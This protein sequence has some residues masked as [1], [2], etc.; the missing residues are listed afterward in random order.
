MSTAYISE[1]SWFVDLN[2][3]S[4]C[5]SSCARIHDKIGGAPM[6]PS[7]ASGFPTCHRATLFSRNCRPLF[8][9]FLF[10]TS[11]SF[12]TQQQRCTCLMR[13]RFRLSSIQL[14]LF[15]CFLFSSS[16]SSSSFFSLHLAGCC[17]IRETRH[18]SNISPEIAKGRVDHWFR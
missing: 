1:P 7:Y 12:L 13:D 17:P 10:S 14:F 9:Y 11:S 3:F 2:S 16:S 4:T 15:S 6:A 8:F 5:L 18:D